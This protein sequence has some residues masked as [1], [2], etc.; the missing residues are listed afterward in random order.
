MKKID[1][2]RYV[3]LKEKPVGGGVISGNM[4]EVMSENMQLRSV[5]KL[6]EPGATIYWVSNNDWSMHELLLEILNIT[7]EAE[8]YI[9]SYAMSETPARILS[10]LKSTGMITKLHSVLD[11][12]IDVR[13][14]GSYQLMKAISDELVL[15]DTHAKVTVVQNKN[16]NVAVIGS[17]NYTENK[18]YE[19]GVVTLNEEAVNLQLLWMQKALRDGV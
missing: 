12:R 18:R 15:V 2:N 11:N 10:Q 13:T 7:G 16:W 5:V 8:V 19:A 17:A 6:I 9:S 4:K 3:T 14:A 1:F